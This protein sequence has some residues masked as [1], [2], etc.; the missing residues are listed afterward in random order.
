MPRPKAEDVQGKPPYSYIFLCAQAIKNNP[1][2]MATLSEI[3]EF[4]MTNY[5]YYRNTSNKWQNSLRHNLSFNDCFVKVERKGGGKGN[6]WR[7]HEE[8]YRMFEEGTVQRRKKRFV[9][10]TCTGSKNNECQPQYPYLYPAWNN[11][12]QTILDP[13]L[14]RASHDLYMRSQLEEESCIHSN[15]LQNYDVAHT[16][17]EKEAHNFITHSIEKILKPESPKRKKRLVKCSLSPTSSSSNTSASVCTSYDK[18]N[19]PSSINVSHL[20]SKKLKSYT[21]SNEIKAPIPVKP[22]Q[23]QENH[24]KFYLGDQHFLPPVPVAHITPEQK[25]LLMAHFQR[26]VHGLGHVDNTYTDFSPRNEYNLLPPPSF[27]DDLAFSQPGYTCHPY[28]SELFGP[29][30]MRVAPL[31]LAEP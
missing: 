20:S 9:A 12:S 16:E 21:K 19:T 31:L 27:N 2:Q 7:L 1:S 30:N 25:A 5:P 17:N 18:H 6:Y 15:E 29:L 13:Q 4:I 22:F 3:Y 10:K 24:L 23:Y 14:D 11:G 8:A 28:S 26:Q